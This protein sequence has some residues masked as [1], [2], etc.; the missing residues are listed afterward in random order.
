MQTLKHEEAHLSERRHGPGRAWG[1]DPSAPFPDIC[2]SGSVLTWGLPNSLQTKSQEKQMYEEPLAASL[3]SLLAAELG[4]CGRW[5]TWTRELS[6]R[7]FHCCPN[8]PAYAANLC[9]HLPL[10]FSTACTQK[11]AAWHQLSPVPV[12][13]PVYPS[14]SFCPSILPYTVSH[15]H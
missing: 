1:S 11:W 4:L 10:R 3:L 7:C 8:T 15:S 6:P 14:R 13:S 5:C 12:T 2:R 9:P